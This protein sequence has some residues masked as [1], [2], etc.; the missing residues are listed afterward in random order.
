MKVGLFLDRD[1][2]INEEAEY[3][4]DPRDVHLLPGAAQAIR[5]ANNL[6]LPVFIISNQSGVARGLFS[7]KDVKRVNMALLELLE[8]E[9]ASIDGI[10]YCPHHPDFGEPEYRKDCSCRKPKIGML[11]QAG[12]KFKIDLKKSFVVGDKMTDVQTGNVAGARSILVLTGYGRKEQRLLE[13][14][15][16]HVDFVAEDLPEAMEF[17]HREMVTEQLHSHERSN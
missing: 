5:E 4:S 2:T 7:E 17:V 3:L 9:N 8:K 6:G 14:N 12:K 15:D 1:G 16:V 13:E 10:F 11:Q